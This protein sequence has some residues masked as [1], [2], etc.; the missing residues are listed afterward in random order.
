VRGRYSGTAA[1]R[2]L[3]LRIVS[4]PDGRLVADVTILLGPTERSA[5]Y[6]GTVSADGR[7]SLSEDGGSGR[8]DLRLSGNDLSGTFSSGG[9]KPLPVKA[10][11][12]G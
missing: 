2:P 12:N 10:S 11:K 9:G 5:R 4:Q 8:L 7:L 1:G 3:Q 6:T